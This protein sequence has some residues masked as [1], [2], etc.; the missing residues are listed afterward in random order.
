MGVALFVDPGH[1][2]HTHINTSPGGNVEQQHIF[3]PFFGGPD[4]RLALEFVV[5]LCANP[6][7]G[8]TVVRMEKGGVESGVVDARTGSDA[9]AT[10]DINAVVAPHQTVTSVSL[11]PSMYAM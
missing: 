11:C 1:T 2:H 6:K 5:Q 3:F 9:D 4:D 7:M 8:A 10:A